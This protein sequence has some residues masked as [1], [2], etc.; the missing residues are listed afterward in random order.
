MKFVSKAT[1]LL[2]VLRPGM[3]AQPLTGTPATPTLS[4]RFK[5]GVVEVQQPE[6]IEMMLKHPAFNGDFIAMDE[7]VPKSDPYA[8]SRKPSEPAHV[9]TEMKYGTPVARQVVGGGSPFASLPPAMQK[10]V[11]DMAGEMAKAMVPSLMESTLKSLMATRELSRQE[12]I[13]NTEVVQASSPSRGRKSSKKT[14]KSVACASEGCGF[15]AKNANG[16]RL[17]T[18]KHTGE[19]SKKLN[20]SEDT[21]VGLGG[22][23]AAIG[24]LEATGET[25]VGEATS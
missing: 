8:A 19:L 21:S 18:M 4:V 24:G 16:L 20:Y 12:G 7:E 5:D 10:L 11:Q 9:L 14:D 22:I 2:I 23:P 1:N 15:V 6:L 17:H 25:R 3:S 13:S